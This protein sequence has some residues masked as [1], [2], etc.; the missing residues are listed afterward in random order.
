MDLVAFVVAAPA[1][2]TDLCL[3]RCFVV[4]DRRT[5]SLPVF[6]AGHHTGRSCLSATV[7][8]RDDV[9]PHAVISFSNNRRRRLHHTCP[10]Q[11]GRAFVATEKILVRNHVGSGEVVSGRPYHRWE[12]LIAFCRLAAVR[13][14]SST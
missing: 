9:N 5:H 8:R 6:S 11:F 2:R 10:R 7:S 4:E 1:R 12:F 14:G 13:Q 3:F